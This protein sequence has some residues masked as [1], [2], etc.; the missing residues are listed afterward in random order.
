MSSL[1]I[2]LFRDFSLTYTGTL[3]PTVRQTRQPFRLASLVSCGA[4]LVTQFLAD[5]TQAPDVLCIAERQSDWG[6]PEESGQ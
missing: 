6:L 2:H 5:P 1:T 4:A 3:S